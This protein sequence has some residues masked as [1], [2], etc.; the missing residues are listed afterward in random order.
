MY[1]Q[2]IQQ[3]INI[4]PKTTDPDSR[5]ALRAHITPEGHPRM[6]DSL[7]TALWW[8]LP[9]DGDFRR[10]SNGLHYYL[11][12][13]G[14]RVILRGGNVTSPLHES[15]LRWLHDPHPQQTP[16]ATPPPPPVTE[17]RDIVPRNK[18]VVKNS[19]ARVR[20]P[21]ENI[22]SNTWYN[23]KHSEPRVIEK[24]SNKCNPVSRIMQHVENLIDARNEN[25]HPPRP[26]K[27]ARHNAKRQE[28]RQHERREREESFIHEAGD[29]SSS[30]VP[31]RMTQ[32]G[33]L[34]R[35]PI[36]AMRPA[37]YPPVT[38]EGRPTA[39]ENSSL[40]FGQELGESTGLHPGLY[41][42]AI[43]D[44]QH[45]NWANS[46]AVTN[47]EIGP[48][49]PTRN[50]AANSAGDRTRTG[51]VYPL[52]PRN[53]RPDV[54]IEVEAALPEPA[55]LLR[56]DLQQPSREAPTRLPRPSRRLGRKRRRNRASAVYR[57]AKRSPPREY[58]CDH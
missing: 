39:N 15:R 7:R 44:P 22:P 37:V 6:R 46:S 4:L 50:L 49:S 13:Q 53:K 52:Q 45:H 20:A 14:R 58:W 17:N 5:F 32:I 55:A 10:A 31:G 57:P 33:L 56:P 40:Q 41:K 9:K 43:P 51:I 23:S 54:C 34:P 47:A 30:A 1:I 21:L 16:R 26:A 19:D 48:P 27:K 24:R 11:A 8:L 12:R 28:R 3:V 36:S 35:D 18:P 29:V 42:P 38:Q 25:M 2:N